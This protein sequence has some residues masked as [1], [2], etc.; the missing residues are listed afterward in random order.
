M[1]K[2]LALQVMEAIRAAETHV[3]TLEALSVE[4]T[5]DQ[6]RKSFR[7]HLAE[8]MI[9]Y[10]DLQM[11]I[12]RKYPDLDPDGKPAGPTEGANRPVKP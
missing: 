10:I 4:I 3:N 12:V 11:L 8:V 1:E 6:E 2:T 7:R 5:D 9:G